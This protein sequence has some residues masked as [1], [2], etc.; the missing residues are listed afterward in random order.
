MDTSDLI[1]ARGAFYGPFEGHAEKTQ[2]I[3]TTLSKPAPPVIREGYDMI[4]HKLGR[5][6]NGDPSYID[7]WDDIAGYAKLVADWLR[8]QKEWVPPAS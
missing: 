2:I 5:I 8:E 7:S 6:A 3:K 1:K 4:A